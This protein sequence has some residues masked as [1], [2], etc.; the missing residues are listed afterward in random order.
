MQR[1][2][3]DD[4]IRQ[5]DTQN[6]GRCVTLPQ[7]ICMLHEFTLSACEKAAVNRR[8][9]WP[10][11][12]S[13]PNAENIGM[14]REL[15]WTGSKSQRIYSPASP[16]C[17]TRLEASGDLKKSRTRTNGILYPEFTSVYDANS[18]LGSRFMLLKSGTTSTAKQELTTY[19]SSSIGTSRASKMA[20]RRRQPSDWPYC[21]ITSQLPSTCLSTT[22]PGTNPSHQAQSCKNCTWP[23]TGQWG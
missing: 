10:C 7:V 21:I 14:T 5:D 2:N 3:P 18:W 16:P 12:R 4:N 22:S 19:T 17:F 11:L 6:P 1:R 9:T 8:T 15:A 20:G 13:I 23:T